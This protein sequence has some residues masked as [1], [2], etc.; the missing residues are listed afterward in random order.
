MNQSK[1]KILS[2]LENQTKRKLIAKIIG[3]INE[4]NFKKTNFNKL[5]KDAAVALL[6][7]EID[8]KLYDSMISRNVLGRYT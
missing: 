8:M 5:S 2:N 6:C 3:K 7:R 1:K 4:N